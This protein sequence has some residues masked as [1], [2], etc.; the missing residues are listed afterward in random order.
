MKTNTSNSEQF[1]ALANQSITT[2]EM[3]CIKG[4]DGDPGIDVTDPDKPIYIKED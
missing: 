2:F 4:G 1:E 3:K